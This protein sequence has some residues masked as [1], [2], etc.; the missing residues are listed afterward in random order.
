M[1]PYFF[2]HQDRGNSDN[3]YVIVELPY[4]E[5]GPHDYEKSIF[6]LE[7]KV[8][9]LYGRRNGKL[10]CKTVRRLVRSD[11]RY[12]AIMNLDYM[13]K[14]DLYYSPEFDKVRQQVEQ[15]VIWA[16]LKV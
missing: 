15:H 9:I 6:L 10:R 8:L 14:L 2:G 7:Q 12:K 4:D 13:D 11:Y 3:V 5:E 1:K 16:M